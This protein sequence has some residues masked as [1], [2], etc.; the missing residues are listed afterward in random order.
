[1]TRVSRP[2]RS[3]AAATSTLKRLA[4]VES[5]TTTSSSSAPT[6]RAIRAPTRRGASHQSCTFHD[7]MR[8][9]PHC[10]STT[11]LTTSGT[12][13][14]SGA[15]RVAVEIDHPVRQHE[16]LPCRRE[17]VVGVEPSGAV[18]GVSQVHP[19]T[20]GRCQHVPVPEATG[21]GPHRRRGEPGWDDY[22]RLLDDY[23]AHYGR[24]RDPAASGAG[25]DRRRCRPGYRCYLAEVAADDGV[26]RPAAVGMALVGPSPATMALS[27]CWSAA[28]PVRRRR[29]PWHGVGRALVGRVRD[30]ARAAGASRL[31][32]QTEHDNTVRCRSTAASASATSTASPAV[33]P[34]DAALG[35]PYVVAGA[36]T[37]TATDFV[38]GPRS[39]TRARTVAVGLPRRR[40]R[41]LRRRRSSTSARN[42]RRGRTATGP[43]AGDGQRP[44]VRDG[45]AAA[46]STSQR[47]NAA[48][49]PRR[50]ASARSRRASSS[51]VCATSSSY[52]PTRVRRSAVR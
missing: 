34:S 27:S 10:R 49:R 50:S 30:D 37:T 6:R 18:E 12:A 2:G 11:S 25:W 1:M 17:R 13:A 33:T 28:R 22:V 26:G 36:Q 44:A 43:A 51:R 9:R 4:D 31:A 29:P 24:A 16:A 35:A 41:R 38:V 5:A 40:R 8:S 52:G 45:V 39:S 15:Q 32:L 21:P 23:R 20:L 7:V 48:A 3:R 46:A 47:G 19:G 42:V 14:G